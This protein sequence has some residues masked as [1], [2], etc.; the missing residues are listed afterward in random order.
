[1]FWLDD[2]EEETPIPLGSMEGF[3]YWV[4][5]QLNMLA[6]ACESYVRSNG[7]SPP[8]R[9]TQPY[10]ALR[11]TWDAFQIIVHN[12]A[13]Y[14]NEEAET[15]KDKGFLVFLKEKIS[16]KHPAEI[17]RIVSKLPVQEK[18]TFKSI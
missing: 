6:S 5:T 14:K 2:V 10:Y 9:L 8:E 16:V 1:M 11:D 3:E 4:K 15:Y 17:K 7:E 12:D 13:R 18:R